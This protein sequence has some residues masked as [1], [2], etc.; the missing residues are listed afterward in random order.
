MARRVLVLEGHPAVSKPHDPI[1]ADRHPKPKCG[2]SLQFSRSVVQSRVA[3]QGVGAAEPTKGRIYIR[4]FT[5]R[6]LANSDALAFLAEDFA[7]GYTMQTTDHFSYE[8]YDR[9]T[10][11]YVDESGSVN[12]PGL[13]E[14]LTALKDFIE[15]LGAASPEN[16]PEWF[17]DQDARKRYYLS[18][19]L[20]LEDL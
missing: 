19:A 13:K 1:D 6:E 2:G 5:S 12:Y 20:S 10:R 7:R 15:Q 8:E 16:K 4:K 17:P 3:G 14:E 18:D 11:I 9:L